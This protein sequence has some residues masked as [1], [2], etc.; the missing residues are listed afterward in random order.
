M[1]RFVRAD[2]ITDVESAERILSKYHNREVEMKL[3]SSTFK[4][5]LLGA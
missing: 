4:A 5:N 3:N 1:L 2:K